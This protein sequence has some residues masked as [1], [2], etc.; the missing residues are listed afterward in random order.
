MIILFDQF[1]RNMYRGTPEMSSFD[2]NALDTALRAVKEG[3]EG[4]LTLV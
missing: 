1:S 2:P 4:E 3:K